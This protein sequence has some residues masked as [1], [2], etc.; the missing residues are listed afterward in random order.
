MPR[1]VLDT[2]GRPVHSE[3]ASRYREQADRFERLAGTE[4]RPDARAQLL[5]LA[6][7][8]AQLADAK[9]RKPTAGRA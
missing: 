8:Y 9:P 5:R 4:T 3:R 7:E 1:R 6:D 2:E